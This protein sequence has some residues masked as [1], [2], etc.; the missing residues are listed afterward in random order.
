MNDNFTLYELE[1]SVVGDPTTF[2]CGH[3]PGRAFRVIGEDVVFNPGNR[4]SQYALAA[5][6]PL[7]PA[8]QRKTDGN[9]WMT[10]DA[11]IACPDPHCKA[12]FQI[13]RTRTHTYKHSDITNVPLPKQT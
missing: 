7:L 9:D 2:V 1:V 3:T 11:L 8:K 4:F 5:L 12:Q 10:T 13:T 6:L